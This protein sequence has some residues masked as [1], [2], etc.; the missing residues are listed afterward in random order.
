VEY[1]LLHALAPQCADV[2]L[3]DGLDGDSIN[4]AIW[5]AVRRIYFP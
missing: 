5:E 2:S 3:L 4:P 1:D